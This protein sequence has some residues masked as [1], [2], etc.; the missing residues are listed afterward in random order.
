[1]RIILLS[2]ALLFCA[3]SAHSQVLKSAGVWY[4][5]DVDS[6]TARPAVLPN[7]TELAYVVGTKTVYYWNRN[8]STWTAYGSTFNRD[9]IYFDA[10]I[11]GSGTV[12]DPWGVDST[13]FATIAGVGDSIAAALLDYVKIVDTAAMLINYPSTAG[14]GIIDAGKTWRADTTS[15]NGLATRLFAKTLP[16][17]IAANYAAVSNGTNLIARNLFDNNTYAGVIGRPW[18]FGE[19]TTASLP[20][21][22]AGYTVY[23]TTINGPGW[24]QGSRW[25][26]ALE[27]TFARGTATRV[28]FF[29]ANGQ[30]T[31]ASATGQNM[32]YYNAGSNLHIL[33][34]SSALEA[35]G[36][37]GVNSGN[38]DIVV[39]SATSAGGR[40]SF[41]AS[42]STGSF[43]FFDA[44]SVQSPVTIAKNAGNSRLTIAATTTT[45]TASASIISTANSTTETIGS[46][47]DALGA[48][49]HWRIINGSNIISLTSGSTSPYFAIT[50]GT[51]RGYLQATTL[52]GVRLGSSSN[53]PLVFLTNGTVRGQFSTSGFLGIAT[54]TPLQELDVNGDAY[55]R[56]STRLATTP[57]HAAITGLLT[58]DATGWVGLASLAGGLSYSGGVLT[59]ANIYNSDGTIPS[60][61]DRYITMAGG[62][63]SQVVLYNSP[64]YNGFEFSAVTVQ[65]KI[66]SFDEVFSRSAY[67]SWTVT[68]NTSDNEAYYSAASIKSGTTNS[69]YQLFGAG[70]GVV[71][72][73][74]RLGILFDSVSQDAVMGIWGSLDS[75]VSSNTSKK[76][77]FT[78]Y[79]YGRDV[80]ADRRFLL[81]NRSWTVQ[82][83]YYPATNDLRPFNWI[84]IK[85][86]ETDTT[87]S[88]LW[89]Y[90]KY[91][92]SNSTPGTGRNVHVWDNGTPSFVEVKRDT[93]IYI[94][95]ADYDFSAAITT[96]QI[97]SRFNRVIFWMTTTGAAGS[98]S[99]LTLHTPDVNLMQVEYLIHSVDEAGGFENKIVF[100]TNNAVDSTNG[101]VTNYYPA[102]GDGVHI[103]AALRSG[104]YKYRYS[105]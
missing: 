104:V 15:P 45:N 39:S 80:T 32:R 21:G 62:T 59:G 71:R 33:E 86:I 52:D 102:A 68:A 64:S 99:E 4:F 1:M 48:T 97:A 72:Q 81:D 5:L 70:R 50:N 3:F 29:D 13:L 98:D 75:L 57:A 11:V 44:L 103:R 10:S 16:T 101:L 47:T 77:F 105:N 88:S 82:S 35:K 9:S 61:T 6:M 7:G 89:V 18:K 100:G 87:S 22:V 85:N 79:G 78:G 63:S 65:G 41:S 43:S 25:A 27:S 28:P 34:V 58:R 83:L 8:T 73:H 42:E 46:I 91:N 93:T 20:I 38:G 54:T 92:L 23:N 76:T 12:S 74:G 14:Y 69:S 40:W 94:D 36:V 24:Y 26:Y 84:Q 31:Q 49:G 95:D 96:A 90:E 51:Q 2:I 37:T 30:I 19:Y 56:D 66:R 67:K 53:H 60:G 17:T 55:I